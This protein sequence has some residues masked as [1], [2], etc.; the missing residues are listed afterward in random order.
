MNTSLI[1]VIYSFSKKDFDFF[2]WN[3]Q[4]YYLHANRNLP[5]EFSGSVGNIFIEKCII[6]NQNKRFTFLAAGFKQ[7]EIF[8]FTIYQKYT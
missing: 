4:C 6:R 8:A 5:G 2:M 7:I 3:K 1:K